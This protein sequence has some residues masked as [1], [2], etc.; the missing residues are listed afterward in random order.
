MNLAQ[1][2]SAQPPSSLLAPLPAYTHAG[3]NTTSITQLLS[4]ASGGDRDAFNNLVPLVYDE[5]HRIAEAYLRRELGNRTLQPTALIHEAYLRLAHNGCSSY[6]N[7]AH[8]FGVA[9]R[10]MR[11]ILVDHAR[12]RKAGKRGDGLKVPLHPNLDFAPERDRVVIALDDALKVLAT[13]DERKASLV[14]MRFFAGM[15]ANEIAGVYRHARS[16]RAPRTPPRAGL[17]PPGDRS[18]NL[19]VERLLDL[20]SAMPP[21]R[22]AAFL[23]RALPDATVRREVESLLEYVTGAEEYFENAIQGV[24]ACVR[25]SREPASGDAFGAYRVRLAARPRRHGRR[26]PRRTRRRRTAAAGRHQTAARRLLPPRLARAL[27]HR[28]P[29][30]R[31]APASLHHSCAR[32]RPHAGRPPIPDHGICRPASPST[33]TPPTLDVRG[34]LKLFLRVCDGV[35]HAH[36]RLII[37]RDLK[38]SNILVDASGQPK[39]LDFGIAKLLDDSGSTQTVEQVLTPGYASPEQLSG[40]RAKHRHRYL[41][42]RRRAASTAHRSDSA[43][44]HCPANATTSWQPPARSIRRCPGTSTSSSPRPCA[45][46]PTIATSRS[47][48]SPPTSAPRSTSAPCRRAPAIAATAPAASCAATGCPSPPAPPSSPVSPPAS[49][50]PI[51]NASS[52]NAVS[53]PCAQLANKFFEVDRQVAQLPG[54]SK[55]R[56][57]IVDTALEYLQR[58]TADARMDASLSLDLATAYMRVGRVLGVNISPNLGQTEQA[59]LAAAKAAATGRIGARHRARAIAPHCCAP[60]RSRTTA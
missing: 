37:H 41:L 6:E 43:P 18:V 10:V 34:R 7:R 60:R 49:T 28:T 23:T 57:L 13:Q 14:E 25:S 31:L 54:S 39:L 32:C 27:S 55:T 53:S 59:D 42:A 16:H 46:N 29:A 35:S 40:S 30:A 38:P 3:E 51:G 36:R 21:E 47:T 48:N 17:A 22:R 4:R 9:A 8:F 12:S 24:A 33:P 20:A 15:T 2:C 11:Q 58:M 1:D 44:V 45:P 56:Q 50:S 52:P 19:E 5:L 26:L